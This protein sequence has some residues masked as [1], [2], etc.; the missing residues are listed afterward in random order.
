MEYRR[1]GNSDLNVSV[2]CQGCWS[3]VSEDDTWGPNRLEDSIAAIH[4]SLDAGV[5]FFDTAEVYGDGESEE[6]LGRALEGKRQDVVI[7]TKVMASR[8]R[9]KPLKAACEAGLRRLRS[10]YVDLYQI[11]WPNPDV[12]VDESLAAMEELHR[13]GKV[14]HLGVSNFGVSF[15]NE[16]LAAGRIVSNQ[17]P[18]SLL[19]RAIEDGVQPLCAE[20]QVSILAYSP[21]CQSLLTGKF[22]SPR[23]VP[24]GRARMRVFSKDRSLSRH[25]ENGCEE[26]LFEALAAI[27]EICE[28]LGRPMN[29]AALAWLLARQ[30]VASVVVGSRTA[31]QARQN[32]P[33]CDLR[34]SE[35][36]IAAL[37]AAGEAVRK[38]LGGNPDPWQ[39]DSR[40]ER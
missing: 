8:L 17:L 29:H 10:D 32:A 7:A 9:A 5:N 25:G 30:A 38:H 4:A 18:Y 31:Q 11:H 39:S 13:E 14:R 26:E 24:D 3:L 21:L 12:P 37:D 36:T 22:S 23:E 27:R 16:A 6:I 20:N 19:W 15:L 35:D 34:L 2:I 40:F 33:A 28:S 1:L